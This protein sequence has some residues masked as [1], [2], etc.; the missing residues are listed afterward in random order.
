M[1][2]GRQV[3]GVAGDVDEHFAPVR[4][5][6]VANIGE[7]GDGGA[8]FCA[9]VEGRKVVDLWAGAADAGRPWARGTPSATFS[10]AKGLVAVSALLLYDQGLLELDVPVA[11][12]WPEFGV[13][14]KAGITVRQ[15][16]SNTAG[17]PII[18]GYQGFLDADHP[19]F[20]A[21]QEIWRRLA[22]AAPQLAPGTPAYHA[23]TFGYLVARIVQAVTGDSLANHVNQ[24]LVDRLGLEIWFGERALDELGS[25]A[26]LHP[27]MPMPA[28]L[29]E[30]MN[31]GHE[32]WSPYDPDTL[33]GKAFLATENGN[34]L[35]AL[36]RIGM[37]P[38]VISAGVGVGD[39]L[40]TARGLATLYAL[41]TE[42]GIVD[43][44]QVIKPASI[45]EF[46]TVQSHGPDPVL[47]RIA[48][49]TVGF[50]GNIERPLLGTLY[51]PHPG[52]FGKDGAGGQKGF[53]DP[54]NRVAVGFVRSH[55]AGFSPL[56]ARL[57]STLYECL[58]APR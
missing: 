46:T 18:P 16:L 11:R 54:H 6:F 38:D 51:G 24:E 5:T 55:L 40:A 12:Y 48:N 30:A 26:R 27:A 3:G 32:P 42:H 47:G 4:D 50:E 15:V 1:S 58:D 41:L 17:L 35:D 29:T 53:A 39:A 13:S 45:R 33:P 20:A 44:Q 37:D 49:W 9:F 36:H 31:G 7:L 34:V 2:A 25:A 19:N 14:G 21:R 8:G 10:A 28:V 57:I 22:L 52:A 56:S 43:G 23:M